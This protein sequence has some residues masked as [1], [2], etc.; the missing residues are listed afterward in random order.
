MTSIEKAK[1][2]RPYIEKAVSIAL[3]DKEG[4]EAVELFPNWSINGNYEIGF[5]VKY[6]HILYRCNFKNKYF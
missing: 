5:R 3:T 2:L 1:K 4:I 6:E